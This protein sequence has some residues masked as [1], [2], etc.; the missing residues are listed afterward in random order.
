[1]SKISDA[2]AAAF[3]AGVPFK[4]GNT[5][6]VV[7][8]GVHM[9]LHHS[10]IAARLPGGL[11]WLRRSSAPLTQTTK[12]RMNA[13]PDVRVFTH[14]GTDYVM[15]GIHRTHWPSHREWVLV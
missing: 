5:E 7:D 9:R 11:T 4:Q 1:M 14:K 10:I 13:L 8:C 6:V 12:S 15:D 3:V 2:A